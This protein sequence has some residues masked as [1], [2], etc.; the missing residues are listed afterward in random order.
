MH[1]KMLTENNFLSR[2]YFFMESTYMVKVY[3][4]RFILSFFFIIFRISLNASEIIPIDDKYLADRLT[5][6]T[7]TSPIKSNPS[8]GIIEASMESLYRLHDLRPCRKIIVFDGVDKKNEIYC[9][10][11]VKKIQADYQLYKENIIALTQDPSKPHFHN[12][13]LLFLEEF[14]HQARA[15]EKA[16]ELVETPYI[17]SHQHD[18]VIIRPFDIRGII[19]TMENNPNIR[20]VRAC[21]GENGPNYFDGPV[22]TYVEGISFIPLVRTFRFSDSE[23]FTTVNFY[24]EMVFPKVKGHNFAEYWVMEPN[25]EKM[26]E[27]I[28]RNHA[29]WGMYIYGRLGEPTCLKHLDGRER[30]E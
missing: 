22:D 20:L 21:N 12:T 26:Q 17:Y 10:K 25:F 29:Q 28:I 16:M 6:I 1:T 27:E 3:S 13:K 9:R 19:R 14:S 24:K 4:F 5:I 11:D 18:I 23:H 7:T 2:V 8:T 15:L 30:H